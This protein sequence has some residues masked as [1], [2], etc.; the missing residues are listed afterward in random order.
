MASAAK[1]S[2]NQPSRAGFPPHRSPTQR[3]SPWQRPKHHHCFSGERRGQ[4][5]NATEDNDAVGVVNSSRNGSSSNS[6]AKMVFGNC[7]PKIQAASELHN[8]TV[9]VYVPSRRTPTIEPIN[10]FPHKYRND[11]PPSH[12]SQ[13]CDKNHYNAIIDWNL[14]GLQPGLLDPMQ[15][16]KAKGEREE[17]CG[18]GGGEFVVGSGEEQDECGEGEGEGCYEGESLLS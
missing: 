8:C 9:Q 16:E 18:Y 3:A 6:C 14:Q 12:T 11:F 17:R 13:F 4:Q 7:P 15:V 5:G 2:R 1:L 10:I